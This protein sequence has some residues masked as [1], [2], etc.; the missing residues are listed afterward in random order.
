MV[1]Q[2]RP[3]LTHQHVYIAF[4]RKGCSATLRNWIALH[5]FQ[6]H[7]PDP[8]LVERIVAIR[9]GDLTLAVT[10]T[11]LPVKSEIG[12]GSHFDN[13]SKLVSRSSIAFWLVFNRNAD[14]RLF[15][16]CRG[17]RQFLRNPRINRLWIRHTPEGEAP[18]CIGSPRMGAVYGAFKQ[19]HLA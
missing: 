18:D 19:V 1:T 7:I 3:E 5:P 8:A 4:L 17:F 9:I 14:S 2:K 16:Y 6:V 15:S 12:R 11:D 13:R 10:I